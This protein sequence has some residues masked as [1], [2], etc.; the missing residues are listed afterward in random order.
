MAY[1]FIQFT[2]GARFQWGDSRNY[3]LFFDTVDSLMQIQLATIDINIDIDTRYHVTFNLEL[4]ILSVVFPGQ[5]E[6]IE[7]S[8]GVSTIIL[9]MILQ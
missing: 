4:L 5:K 9:L 8:S 3:H 2:L 7:K 6:K 1:G